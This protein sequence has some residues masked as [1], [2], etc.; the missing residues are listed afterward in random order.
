[1]LVVQLALEEEL[2]TA[3]GDGLAD[4][5]AMAASIW[6]SRCSK[7][8]FEWAQ[9]NVD[10]EVTPHKGSHWVAGPLYNGRPCMCPER[11]DFWQRRL[12]ELGAPD[13]GLLPQV[14]EAVHRAAEA[15]RT[16]TARVSS[17]EAS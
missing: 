2:P 12:E 15:M 8:L 17:S 7:K 1:M 16:V 6:L 9:E 10:P 4:C 13:S 11:W 3:A 5:R 14:R